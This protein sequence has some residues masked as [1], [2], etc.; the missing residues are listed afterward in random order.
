[1]F[2]WCQ[3]SPR[4]YIKHSPL[5]GYEPPAKDRKRSRILSDDEFKAVWRNSAARSRLVFRLMM[6]WG[7]RNGETCSIRRSWI[8][9]DVL[10]IPGEIAKNGRDHA[11]PLLPMAKAVLDGIPNTG[12]TYFPGQRADHL[13]PGSLKGLHVQ[14]KRETGTSGWTPHDIRRTARS[15]WSRL[16][17]ATDVCEAMLNHAPPGIQQV[18]NRYT[19][20]EEKREALAKYETFIQTLVAEA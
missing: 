15:T 13:N 14:I 4:R 17:I 19:Y 7:T 16:R 20:L 10:T 12:D 11:I 1:M 18:Y 3:R 8:V 2:R 9:D 6:L 5:E